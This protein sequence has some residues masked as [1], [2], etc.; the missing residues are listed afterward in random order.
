M[1]PEINTVHV[2]DE[3]TY[4]TSMQTDN[5][6]APLLSTTMP[7]AH[8]GGHPDVADSQRWMRS[9]CPPGYQEGGVLHADGARTTAG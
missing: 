6:S 9:V 7:D 3:G 4:L 8:G 5:I 2:V 1:H